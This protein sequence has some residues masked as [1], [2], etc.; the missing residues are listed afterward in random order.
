[1]LDEHDHVLPDKPWVQDRRLTH[2][3]MNKGLMNDYYLAEQEQKCV[4]GSS[5]TCSR[6]TE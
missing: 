3:N 4:S 6:P 5:G 1:M 2:C